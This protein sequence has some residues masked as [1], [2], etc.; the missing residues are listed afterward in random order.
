MC[1]CVYVYVF[2][3]TFCLLYTHIGEEGRPVDGEHGR[4]PQ[5]PHRRGTPG[6]V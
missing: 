6:K 4:A 2:S 5:P 1:I 3:P